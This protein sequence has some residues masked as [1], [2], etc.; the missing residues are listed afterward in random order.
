MSNMSNVGRRWIRALAG[1]AALAL[2]WEPMSP[3][4]PWTRAV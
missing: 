3:P 4:S 2:S 1:A